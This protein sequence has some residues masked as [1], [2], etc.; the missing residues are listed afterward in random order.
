MHARACVRRERE[1][2]VELREEKKKKNTYPCE[3]GL[4]EVVARILM[5][6]ADVPTSKRPAE[7]LNSRVVTTLLAFL[8]ASPFT[9]LAMG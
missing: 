8:L 5:K 1:R 2:G 6:P 7:E 4:D 3:K 9:K